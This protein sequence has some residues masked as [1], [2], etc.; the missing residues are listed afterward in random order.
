MGTPPA[1]FRSDYGSFHRAI[2][3]QETG[4]RYGIA[5]AEGSGAMGVGQIMPDTARSL[6]RRLGLPFRPDLLAGT[7]P[8]AKQYQDRLTAAATREAWDYGSGDVR[9]AAM[10]YHGGSNRQIWGPRTRRYADDVLGRLGAR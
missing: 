7:S 8:E 3:G 5:N 9:T 4:G 6:S 2:I 10:Y 1:T